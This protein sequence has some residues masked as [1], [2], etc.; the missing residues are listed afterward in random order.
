MKDTLIIE[1]DNVKQIMLNEFIKKH[2][3]N[4]D[5]AHSKSEAISLLLMKKYDY[6]FID[7]Y[8]PD[9]NGTEIL[10][11]INLQNP[12]AKKI[13]ISTDYFILNSYLNYGYDDFVTHSY[14]FNFERVFK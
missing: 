3:M 11:F 12:K 8:L 1:D 5:V 10:S 7:H 9:G 13:T 2:T 14:V 6:I 4:I